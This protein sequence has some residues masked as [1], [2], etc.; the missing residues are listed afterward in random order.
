M[1][2][3]PPYAD[4]ATL[5][6]W[7]RKPELAFTEGGPETLGL[8]IEAASRGID[9]HTGRQFGSATETRRFTAEWFR[10]RWVV[11][12]DD[13]TTT[14]GLTVEVDNDADGTPE[15]EITDY[16]LTPV[17]A[18]GFPWTCVEILPRSMVKPNGL[19]NGVYVS[20]TWGWPEIPKAI[21]TACLIQAAR[22]W[23]RR[24][25]P[26]GPLISKRVDDVSHRWDGGAVDL[27]TDVAASLADFRRYW[28]AV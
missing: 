25:A 18:K 7:M 12:V 13:V 19:R 8:C 27:D 10:D 28:A 9:K 4:A 2:W 3:R 11:D 23:E 1:T 22:L 16:D 6:R 20:A 15:D 5:A 21:E 26:S 24:D 14:E 17:N